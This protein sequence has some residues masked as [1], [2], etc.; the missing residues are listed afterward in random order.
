MSKNIKPFPLREKIIQ[1]ISEFETVRIKTMWKAVAE[2]YAYETVRRKMN[3]LEKE[4]LMY[5]TR[6]EKARKWYSLTEEGKEYAKKI[7]NDFG[8]LSKNDV[9]DICLNWAIDM[10]GYTKREKIFEGMQAI[11]MQENGEINVLITKA[12]DK[13]IKDF[14]EDTLKNK[15]NFMVD[16]V[17]IYVDNIVDKKILLEEI[18]G[19]EGVRIY[20]IK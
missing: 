2:H 6:D 16:T 8:G 14:L 12:K 15:T 7:K 17:Y 10:G 11:N 18:G 5:S 4:G 19:M 13:K 1:V 20:E 9:G 3:E